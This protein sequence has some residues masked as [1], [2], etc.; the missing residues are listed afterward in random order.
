MSKATLIRTTVNWGW[1]T[2][3]EV[4]SIIKT[5][6]WQHAGA[7]EIAESSISG[8]IGSSKR[9]RHWVWLEHLKS[10]SP[11]SGNKYTLSSNANPNE[12]HFHSAQHILF[13]G[14]ID[15]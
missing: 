14:P 10:Q 4:Q 15:W 13:S 1:L 3:S 2:S 7:G 6:T 5:R 9:M 12:R 11:A 8:S